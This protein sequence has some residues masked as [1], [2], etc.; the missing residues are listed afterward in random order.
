MLKPEKIKKL[1][2]Q[3]PNKPGV[4][5]MYDQNEKIIYVGKAKDLKKRLR[6]YFQKNYQHSNLTRKLLEKLAKIDF[7]QVD[8]ELE[9]TIL[10]ST[11]IKQLKPKYNVIMK[12]DK[13]FVYIKITKEDFP[14]I[15]IVRDIKKDGAKYIGPKTAAHKVKDTLKMLKKLFPFRHCGLDIDFLGVGESKHKVKVTRKVIKYPCLDYYI[16]RCVA[17]CIGKST[18]EEYQKIIKNVENFLEGKEGDIFKELESQMR[19]LA[20]D[21]K[22]EKAAKLRDKIQKIRDILE[23]QKVS[24]PRQSDKDVINYCIIQSRAFFNLF[25]IRGGKLVGQENFILSAN[26]FAEDDQNEEI[27][28]AFIKQYYALTSDFPKEI[29]VPHPT[30]E[31]NVLEALLSKESNHK[32][33][34]HIPQKGTKNKLLTM[35]LKN[36]KIYADRSR[37]S[38]K[39]ESNVT[40]EA[41]KRL[42]KILKLPKEPNRIECYDISHLAGTE[43]VGSMVVF[44]KGAPKKAHYRKFKLRTLDNKINDYKSMEEVLKRRFTKIAEKVQK[45]DYKVKKTSKEEDGYRFF[46]LKKDKLTA[47]TLAIKEYSD[48]VAQL[49]SLEIK[50]K[51]RGEK[52]GYKLIRGVMAKTKSK[53]IY[54]ICKKELKDYYQILGFE[55]VKKVPKELEKMDKKKIC[56]VF[57]RFKLKKDPSFSKIP[58]LVVIDGG[59]GQLSTAKKVLDDLKIEIPIISLAKRLEE[60]FI[61]NEEVSLILEKNN[62]ALN[63]L[64]RTRDEAH[65]FAITFNK[66]LRSKKI[67]KK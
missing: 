50:K 33:S 40:I 30:S 21:K 13:S 35:S 19:E 49:N 16:K 18:P 63:L 43:T 7:I 45:R 46:E 25:Q 57:E 48:R 6:Q 61:P 4:Y 2:S 60:I 65:R 34:I 23:K 52:L 8:S 38:W 54:I 29:V 62:P 42:G 12:D 53:R 51:F 31:Q 55:E 15:Q 66:D 17:P 47:G 27:L 37:P 28:D 64:Q 3:T 14:R 58:D 59:K 9:A 67:R 1:I 11:Q 39:K 26:A 44:E 41:T 56:M 5:K 36:A 32:I 22:F 20:Q 10:E 24:D